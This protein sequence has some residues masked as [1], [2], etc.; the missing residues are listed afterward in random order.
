MPKIRPV[1]FRS[2][3]RIYKHDRISS[4]TSSLECA[5]KFA[6]NKGYLIACNTDEYLEL[7]EDIFKIKGYYVKSF[8]PIFEVLKKAKEN[9]G[10]GFSEDFFLVYITLEKKNT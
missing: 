6:K 5:D 2:S 8:Y 4:F 7:E 3:S 1:L 10:W 9:G